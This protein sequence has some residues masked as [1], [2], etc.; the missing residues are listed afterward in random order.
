[1]NII[2]LI[3]REARKRGIRFL[4]IGGHAVNA[5]GYIRLTADVDILVRTEERDQWLNLLREEG[6]RLYEDGG[7]FMQ[8]SPPYGIRWPLDLMFVADESFQP[9]LADSFPQSFGAVQASI[10]SLRH[11]L[12]LKFHALKHGRPERKDKDMAAYAAKMLAGVLTRL[13]LLEAI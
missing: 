1:M 7:A 8:F 4:V 2:D 12:A 13:S 11:L 10:P 6:F 5:H 3:D 9:M